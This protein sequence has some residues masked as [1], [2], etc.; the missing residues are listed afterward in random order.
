[1]IALRSFIYYTPLASVFS[2]GV[3]LAQSMRW[4]NNDCDCD[5]DLKLELI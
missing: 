3:G 1:M 5:W 2:L 4:K